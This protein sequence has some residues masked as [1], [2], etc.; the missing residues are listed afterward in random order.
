VGIWLLFI[1]ASVSETLE[2]LQDLVRYV[3]GIKEE[4][5]AILTV[6]HGWDLFRPQP[7]SESGQQLADSH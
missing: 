2:A 7:G 1:G 6:T 5:K 4:R 3:G